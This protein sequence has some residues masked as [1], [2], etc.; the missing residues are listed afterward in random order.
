MTTTFLTPSSWIGNVKDV[1][2]VKFV[3][4]VALIQMLGEVANY[5][6]T[7]PYLHLRMFFR[8]CFSV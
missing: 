4:F 7:T 1:K 5:G 8:K 3:H 2:G 6:I